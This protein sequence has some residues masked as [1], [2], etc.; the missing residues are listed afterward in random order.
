LFVCLKKKRHLSFKTIIGILEHER[1]TPQE[2]IIDLS[3]KYAYKHGNF[4]DYSHI[5]Q[6]VQTI[7]HDKKFELIEDA[8]IALKQHLKASYRIKKIK[9]KITKPTILEECFVGVCL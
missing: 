2:V 9:I 5:V 1:I 8:L 6:E 7:M 4:I 3:F